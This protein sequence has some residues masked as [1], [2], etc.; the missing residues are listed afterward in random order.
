[1]TDVGMRPT[2][3]FLLLLLIL[4]LSRRMSIGKGWIGCSPLE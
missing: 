1:M 4:M 3:L 2:T